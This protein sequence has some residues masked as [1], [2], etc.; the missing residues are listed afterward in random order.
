[1]GR[2]N[3]ALYFQPLQSLMCCVFPC[4]AHYEGD[5]ERVRSGNMPPQKT[6]T[7]MMFVLLLY[8]TRLFDYRGLN[9]GDD[10]LCY[11]TSCLR[12]RQI[13]DLLYCITYSNLTNICLLFEVFHQECHFPETTASN[14]VCLI[15]CFFSASTF[16]RTMPGYELSS[17]DR[18]EIDKKHL[19]PKCQGLL[20]EAVQTIACG[21]RYCKTCV[22]TI[23]R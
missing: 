1:M 2:R 20:R 7:E 14:F 16:S 3:L 19:C 6:K 22:E 18:S 21:H 17:A 8:V 13:V 10:T 9:K 15:V 12:N 4:C 5:L 23:F 11:V